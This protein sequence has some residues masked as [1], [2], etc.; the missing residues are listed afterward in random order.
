MNQLDVSLGRQ[1]TFLS[2]ECSKSI[3]HSSVGLVLLAKTFPQ[4]LD[5][6]KLPP[7]IDELKLFQRKYRH[8]S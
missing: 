4:V 2:N 3:K 1:V 7:M 6:V 8:K 5:S